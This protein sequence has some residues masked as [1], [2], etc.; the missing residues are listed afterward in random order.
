MPRLTRAAT[1]QPSLRNVPTLPTLEPR[2]DG[3]PPAGRGGSGAQ[4]LL[5]QPGRIVTRHPL[6]ILAV[7]LLAAAAAYLF[8]ATRPEQFTATSAIAFEDDVAAQIEGDV[9]FVD[10]NRR[11]ATRE[12]L[13]GL[14]VIAQRT[15]TR[16]RGGL[17]TQ[18]VADSVETVSNPDADVIQLEVTTT[19]AR[20][21]A[22][23]ANEYARVFEQ[24]RDE[25]ARRRYSQAIVQAQNSLEELTP[26][27]AAGERGEALRDRI[28]ELQNQ[29][30]LQTGDARLVDPAT[31]P[32]AASAPQPMRT[33]I[34][35]GVLGAL[36]GFGLAALRERGDRTIR[37]LDELERAYG[38]PIIARIPR[39]RELERGHDLALRGEE[40]EAFRLLRSNLR[41][42]NV[43]DEVRSL[44]V[45]SAL[46]AEGKSTVARYLAETMAAMGDRVVLVM[47]DLHHPGPMPGA[48]GGDPRDRLGLSGVLVGQDLEDALVDVAVADGSGA[49]RVL[50]VLP[51]G[52][53]PPNPSQLLESTRMGEVLEELHARY[54]VIVIDSPPAAVLSD[55][56]ALVGRVSGVVAVSAVGRSTRDAVRDCVRNVGLLGGN[57]LG[58]VANFAPAAD[59]SASSYYT[60]R[61]R[62]R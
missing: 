45:T 6:L 27:D 7:T 47:A 23:I 28:D 50:T 30:A 16:L 20:R 62:A 60:E 57:L 31:P 46:P 59:R 26:V 8:S 55:T 17:T 56:L 12:E 52:P 53:M 19:D 40:A 44:L 36:L 29:Q 10:P 24:F 33:A 5:E 32:T 18:E 13:L 1:R 25:S 61:A 14:D 4:G 49:G 54:D 42:F 39:S 21:S 2:S 15:A 43:R 51:P 11:A 22:L 58:V 9:G 3:Q 38:K 34:L 41:Y 35:G 48:D 37:D